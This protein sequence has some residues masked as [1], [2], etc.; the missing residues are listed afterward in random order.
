MLHCDTWQAD[1][2]R[3]A[4][5]GKSAQRFFGLAAA[6]GCPLRDIRCTAE[7]F[8]AAA[9]GRDRAAL[10]A[11]AQKYDWELRVAG[12]SGPGTLVRRLL[13]RPGLLAGLVIFMALVRFFSGYVWAM[14]LR[15]P[16]SR[17]EQ[18]LR[19][20]LAKCGIVE[21]ARLT[22]AKLAQA[23]RTLDQN[24]AWF[25]WLSLNFAGGSLSVEST[26]LARQPIAQAAQNTSLCAKADALVLAVELESGFAL[27]KPGQYVAAGQPLASA[28]RLDRD[29][30]PVTQAAAGRILARVE[31]TFTA[32]QALK[33]QRGVLRGDCAEYATLSLFGHTLPLRGTAPPQDANVVTEWQPL[34][35]GVLALPC[36]LCRQTVWATEDR[37]LAYSA[38]AAAAL[39]RRAC[40][41][42]LQAEFPDA[43][44]KTCESTVENLPNGV[45]CTTRFVFRA[46]IAA[47]VP[48]QG[49][50]FS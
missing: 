49:E 48:G 40:R 4:L 21:G 45:R 42:Q 46:D 27:V 1:S 24:S 28:T 38:E 41:L 15:L 12:R 47:S 7:G 32:V 22:Q 19:A 14:D 23:Q 10:Q 29:G 11:L 34:R 43:E 2:F 17:L 25:G 26:P 6:Q 35:L 3:F 33:E 13:R 9:Q 5:R 44:V 39:A 36:C 8:S 50:A 31:K 16:D 20:Q 18:P 37:E 30:A